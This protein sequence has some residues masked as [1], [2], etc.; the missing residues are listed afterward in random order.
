MDKIQFNFVELV[1]KFIRED[2]NGYA[3]AKA[4]GAALEMFCADV[5]RAD[6]YLTDPERMPEWALDEFAYNN[7]MSWYDRTASVEVKRRWVKEADYMRRCIGTKE[8]VRRLLLG[9]YDY[10]AIDEWFEYG[11]APY[12][13]RV[14]VSGDWS[15]GLEDWAIKAIERVKNLRSV[16]ESFA[17]SDREWVMLSQ[18][19]TWY[20]TVNGAPVD[21]IEKRELFDDSDEMGGVTRT[22]I[23]DQWTTG[24]CIYRV[25]GDT[26]AL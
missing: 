13:F 4:I 16:F 19:D 17:H 24:R 15:E 20:L 7:G 12:T 22:G 2:R 23:C 10:C 9:F 26:A 25:C 11:G 5:E 6:A 21:S 1:P 8:A 3:L 14:S 18:R